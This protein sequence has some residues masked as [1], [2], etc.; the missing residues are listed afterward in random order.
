M[1]KRLRNYYQYLKLID[2]NDVALESKS[3]WDNKIWKQIQIFQHERFIHLVVTALFSIFFILSFINVYLNVS[4]LNAL[5]F[6]ILMI[7]EIF[8]IKHYYF[9]ENYIQKI[10]QEYDRLVDTDFYQYYK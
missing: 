10:Y 4:W 2:A 1:E 9:L 5:L 6:L 7:V 3:L 8:Y